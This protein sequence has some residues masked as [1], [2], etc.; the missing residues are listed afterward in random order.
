MFSSISSWLI[1]ITGIICLS[2]VVELILPDGQ[3][4]K[5]IK[6]IMSFL[7]TLIIILPLPK[8]LNSDKD[9]SNILDF[10]NSIEVDQ[11]YL[12][13]L[14]LDKLNSLQKDIEKDIEKLGYDNVSVYLSCDIFES[15]MNFKSIS[16]DLSQLV[17]TENAEHKDISKIKKDISKIVQ[18][19]IDINEEAILYDE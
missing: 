10:E 1:S 7:V 8:L 5:Y 9:Y 6:G 13:Q 14:N 18:S 2:V 17:I 3:M 11:D 4:N 16:V 12:Y 19:Y 15:K